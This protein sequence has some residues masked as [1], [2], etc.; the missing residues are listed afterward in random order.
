[1]EN[2]QDNIGMLFSNTFEK[3]E[4]IPE[5]DEWDTLSASLQKRNFFRFNATQFNVYYASTIVFCFLACAGVGS[6][7]TYTNFIKPNK[8]VESNLDNPSNSS[9]EVVSKQR[10]SFENQDRTNAESTSLPLD[11][12]KNAKTISSNINKNGNVEAKA[13]ENQVLA[14]VSETVKRKDSVHVQA[15][16]SV[17][18]PINKDSIKAKPKRILYITKQDPILK[19]DTLHA[20]KQKKKW[21]KN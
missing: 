13:K 20:P 6:H 7:Y 14:T 3:H 12:S 15:N 5:R 18:K 17:H 8:Q 19:F 16:V 1:M 9:L 21:F 11:E 4:I 2:T 10:I